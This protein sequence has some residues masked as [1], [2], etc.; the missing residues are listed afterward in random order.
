MTL[1]KNQITDMELHNEIQGHID[2]HYNPSD[3]TSED[4]IDWDLA[5]IS[6]H[7]HLDKYVGPELVQHH[8][9]IH[10]GVE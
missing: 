5:E 2:A 4:G 10:K 1:P 7:E 3:S 6:A 8:F 9:N